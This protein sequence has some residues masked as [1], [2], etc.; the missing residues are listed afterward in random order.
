[1]P[2]S[3]RRVDG[4]EYVIT[5]IKNYNLHKRPSGGSVN[6]GDDESSTVS[7]TVPPPFSWTSF[8]VTYRRSGGAQPTQRM[9][10]WRVGQGWSWG[11]CLRDTRSATPGAASSERS[12]CVKGLGE[13]RIWLSPLGIGFQVSFVGHHRP[14][15]QV[16][17]WEPRPSIGPDK[18]L[19]MIGRT[20]C[21]ASGNRYM[22]SSV[23][24]SKIF[25]TSGDGSEQSHV[26]NVVL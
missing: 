1:M 4:V 19:S 22:T 3:R 23:H 9:R 14:L 15:S 24:S 5:T 26:R 18:C 17:R 6:L 7:S 13:C 10:F 16:R 8:F 25:H 21:K 2:S 20:F 12:D 11:M